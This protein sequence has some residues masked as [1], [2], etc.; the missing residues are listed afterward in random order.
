MIIP[1]AN[2]R[3]IGFTIAIITIWTIEMKLFMKKLLRLCN[4]PTSNSPKSVENLSRMPLV[5]RLSSSRILTLKRWFNIFEWSA[6]F[7]SCMVRFSRKVRIIWQIK[8]DADMN[9]KAIQYLDCSL[10]TGWVPASTWSNP[11]SNKI[12]IPYIT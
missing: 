2:G 12:K 8:I 10:K 5:P 7:A 11:L 3:I 6:L 1:R 4:K 9:P